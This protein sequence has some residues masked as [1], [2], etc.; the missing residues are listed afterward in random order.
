M[1]KISVALFN[2]ITRQPKERLFEMPS[3]IE[4]ISQEVDITRDVKQQKSIEIVNSGKDELDEVIMSPT[5]IF[6]TN[7]FPRENE[8]KIEPSMKLK[9]IQS[10]G[11]NLLF[12]SNEEFSITFDSFTFKSELLEKLSDWEFN[13]LN[14]Q[15]VAE[16]FNMVWMMFH[17]L[18]F[19]EK[20]EIN[21]HVFGKFL[22]FIQEKYDY[23]NNPFH[24]FN[25]GFTGNIQV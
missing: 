17:S 24:N 20:Y 19:L 16:K 18:G 14:I 25:H 10:F 23:R 12:K 8:N 21:T 11:A 3:L 9:K 22:T 2:S 13:V 15:D 7:T 5:N 6:P 1:S 4:Q